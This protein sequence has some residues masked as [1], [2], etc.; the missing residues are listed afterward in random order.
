MEFEDFA[1]DHVFDEMRYE[2]DEYNKAK[3]D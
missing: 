3:T 2:I 1:F